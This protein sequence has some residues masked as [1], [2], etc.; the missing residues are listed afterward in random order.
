MGGRWIPCLVLSLLA[1]PARADA[2]HWLAG[3]MRSAGAH[4]RALLR[5]ADAETIRARLGREPY[6]TLYKRLYAQASRSHDTHDHTV[7]AEQRRANTARAAALC[8][9]LDRRVVQ[10]Q[11]APFASPAARLVL[12]H[13]AATYL[14]A[15]KTD[16]RAKGLVQ[17]TLDIH[18]AQELHLWSDTLDLL[19]GAEPDVLGSR[20]G[21]AVQNVAD[22]AADLYADFNISN[23]LYLRSLVNNHRAKSAAA[24]GLAAVVLNG[25]AF[26]ASHH[27]GRHDPARWL[28]FGLRYVDMTVRDIP[29]DP[30]GG[31]QEG[32]SYLAYAGIET[33]DFLWAWHNYTG[34]ASYVLRFDRP[35][36]PYYSLHARRDLVLPDLFSAPWLERQ[37]L[38]SVKLMLPD[39]TLPP[40]DDSTPGARLFY[41]FLVRRKVARAP[42]FRWAWQR[43]GHYSSGSVDQAPLLLSTFDD[44]VAAASPADSGLGLSFAMPHAG[45]VVFRSSWAAD[46]VYALLLAEHGKAAGWTRT[47]W[48]DFIDGAAGHEHP[49]AGSFLL[50]AHGEALALD[51]GYLGWPNHSDVNRP[52]NHNMLLVDGKGPQTYRFVVPDSRYSE[53]QIV[54]VD[55]RQEGGWAPAHDGMAYLTAAD[56]RNP[57]AQLAE[58]RTRYFVNVP[59]TELRRRAVFLAGRFLLLQDQLRTIRPG[60]PHDY[61]FVLH[62]NGGGSSGGS[63]A[64]LARGGLWTRPKARLRAEIRSDHALRLATREDVH[65][66]RSWQRRTHTV[67]EATATAPAGRT[68]EFLTLLAPERGAGGVYEETAVDPH[69]CVGGPCLRWSLADQHCFAWSGF[70]HDVRG[71]D[72]R[73]ALLRA[74]SGAYCRDSQR[75]AGAFEELAGAP[76]LLLSARFTLTA[77]GR[78]ASWRALLHHHATVGQVRL[79]LPRVAG[80]VPRGS[81]S[82]VAVSEH[83][84]AIRALAP[85]ELTTATSAPPVVANIHLQ[86]HQPGRPRTVALGQAVQL[87]AQHSCAAGG[88][89]RGY[90]WKILHQPELSHLDPAQTGQQHGPRLRLHPPLP[91]IYRVGV[92]VSA[93]GQQAQT[94]LEFEVEGEVPWDAGAPGA[95]AADASGAGDAM[96]GPQLRGYGGG[97]GCT[98]GEA[99]SR[100]TWLL[101]PLL[102]W[103]LRRKTTP[104]ACASAGSARS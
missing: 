31:Y 73:P 88:P 53:G 37:F 32:G 46:G 60:A 76:G 98:A 2:P 80:Q 25:E 36:A 10:G 57:G 50:H 26:S 91:G 38:W 34:G 17:G 62:G 24:L 94:S 51:S 63:F 52:Q 42:L 15:M 104:A 61:S 13:K 23:W 28:D 7:S 64:P 56:V 40:F 21:L 77:A 87:L 11:V 92:T 83:S 66:A 44:S 22:L 93:G 68:V 9:Y 39:G 84:W 71:A 3:A 99:G 101:L 12:G 103:I 96:S 41:G 58:V 19:L 95:R 65:D 47:R 74:R 82:F 14:L 45:Q 85:V 97:C 89:A 35:V 20:R 72:A 81:C 18:T 5:P 49:D 79:L 4:P 54:L 75:L 86:G 55:P 8:F 102:F 59:H 43:T 30:D 69:P 90:S 67:L 33:V 29:T 27:D 1:F 48:G 70:W 6:L 16:S 100:W 78:A